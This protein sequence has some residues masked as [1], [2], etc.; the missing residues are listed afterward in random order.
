MHSQEDW[1]KALDQGR[2]GQLIDAEGVAELSG[3]PIDSIDEL[4]DNDPT[5]PAP[6]A[7]IAGDNVWRSDAVVRWARSR[8]SR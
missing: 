6:A 1:L 4:I 2:R 7:L 8:S 3:V 5:F